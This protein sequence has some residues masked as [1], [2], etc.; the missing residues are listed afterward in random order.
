MSLELR[1]HSARLTLSGPRAAWALR[2]CWPQTRRLLDA[3]PGQDLAFR[4][5]AGPLP[6]ITVWPRP[7]RLIRAL[8]R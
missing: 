6:A 5:K 3:L 8:S 4:V 2:R 7:P 1:D